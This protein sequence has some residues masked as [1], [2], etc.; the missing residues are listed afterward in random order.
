LA[1]TRFNHFLVLVFLAITWGSS[2]ILMKKG[3]FD[4]EGRPIF[5]P[6][7]VA[8]M[9]LSF[10]GIAL[11]PISLRAMGK[12][13]KAD[14]GWIFL[15]GCFGS[16]IPAFLFTNSQKFLDSSVAG[17]LNSLT[18]LFTLLIGVVIFLRKVHRLQ[19]LGVILG[20]IGAAGLISLHGFSSNNQWSYA[21][22][23]V[24][25]TSF[26]GLSVN[27]VQNKLQHI[28]ALQITA[29][30]QLIVAIPAIGYVLY[31]HAPNIISDHPS[32]LSAF[33][34]VAILGLAGTAVAN[35]LYFW[36]TLKTSALFASSVT[37]IM[38]VVAVFWGLQDHEELNCIHGLYTS[39]IL[40]GV[41]LVNRRRP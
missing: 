1:N 18:P 38:P 37:Y 34:Y 5:S 30:A 3:L 13:S 14:L 31:S 22:L 16:G 41:W 15:V 9:R 25:A 8:A 32:G 36:L 2:F 23:I 27:I 10:A 6:N 26:Y 17:I 4:P 39:V 12:I 19:I 28:K 29:I 35:V 24:L 40:A 7:Q 11:L 20:F 21:L 33:G